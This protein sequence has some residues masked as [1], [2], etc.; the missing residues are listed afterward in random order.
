MVVYEPS[1]PSRLLSK[2][3]G[4][5]PTASMVASGRETRYGPVDRSAVV[6]WIVL[7]ALFLESSGSVHRC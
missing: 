4:F 3:D 5:T 2:E 7:G 6:L 1:K